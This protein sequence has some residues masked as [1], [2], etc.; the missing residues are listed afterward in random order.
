MCIQKWLVKNA[1]EGGIESAG[2]GGLAEGGVVKWI[3]GDE[4]Q[5]AGGAR[6]KR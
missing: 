6:W 2:D 5:E 4:G 3:E 1:V